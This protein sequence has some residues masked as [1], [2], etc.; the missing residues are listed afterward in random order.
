[1]YTV[2]REYKKKLKQE[3]FPPMNSL[4]LILKYRRAFVICARRWSC[5]IPP[6]TV[7][8]R[9]KHYKW[10][11][12]TLFLT[13]NACW[14]W[15]FRLKSLR[16]IDTGDCVQ[17]VAKVTK[18]EWVKHN[19]LKNYFKKQF[20]WLYVNFWGFNQCEL[21]SEHLPRFL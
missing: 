12:A 14:I 11:D 4:L 18:T 21:K 8:P 9:I 1:M 13:S 6:T 17:V 15:K 2:Y 20:Q 16:A 10:F 3:L 5:S 19:F 7:I